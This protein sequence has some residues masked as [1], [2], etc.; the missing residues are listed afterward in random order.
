MAVNPEQNK[1]GARLLVVLTCAMGVG[2]FIMYGLS[3]VSTVVIDELGIGPGQFGWLA[4]TCFL[5][6]TFASVGLGRVSDRAGSRT[7]MLVIF[8]GAVCSLAVAA[9]APNYTWLLVAVTLSGAAQ[10]MSNPATNR[11]VSSQV[12]PSMRS[13]WVGVK[14]SGV[15]AS[16]LIAG[17]AFPSLVVAIGWR[18]TSGI[19]ALAFFVLLIF[20]WNTVPARSQ[21]QPSPPPVQGLKPSLES[22]PSAVN[23]LP[24][25]ALYAFLS[26]AALQATNVYL[27]LFSQTELNFS[28]LL[29]GMTA[30]V[31][32]GVG[33][34]ARI[35][36]GV[37]VPRR[38]S[39]SLLLTLGLGSALGS[40]L[41]LLSGLMGVDILLW[42]G[43]ALHGS[44]ALAVNVVLMV[45]VL[46][47]SNPAKVGTASGVVALGMYLGF[48]LGPLIMGLVLESGRD[49]SV[50][51][52]L[53]SCTYIT[54]ALL[55]LVSKYRR[56]RR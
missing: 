31:A 17:L 49:F 22:A 51:W 53:A 24:V 32:G 9:M 2:P 35:A 54:C 29:G 33:L 44:M 52:A 27:P 5:A 43:V 7:L 13:R 25:Y 26:G 8:G 6:A 46:R 30:A 16:Q 15:Q 12:S 45:S 36:W 10:A 48:A 11:F 41:L 28:L 14:Q 1:S 39:S 3:A 42:A 21:N 19:V 55:A 34:V 47:D 20:S 4:T 37:V 38:E 23:N 40:G 50:G 56:R 18:E